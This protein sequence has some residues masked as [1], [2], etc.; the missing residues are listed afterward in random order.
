MSLTWRGKEL[1]AS[2]PF[3]VRYGMDY[4]M[5]LCVAGAKV[6]VPRKT[7]IL[8]GSIQM[9]P[10]T[11]S[12]KM[13]IGQWGSW[14]VK[15]ALPV[16]LG[17]GPFIIRNGFGRGILIKHP[18]LRARPYMVPQTDKFYPMLPEI[19]KETLGL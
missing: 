3:A 5:S 7:T 11:Q 10:T 2:F 12:D 18:G 16:E 8:Q 19:I 6:D 17:T 13:F 9:R 14:S 15:Y 1:A 4:V